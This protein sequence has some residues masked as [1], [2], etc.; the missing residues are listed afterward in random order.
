MAASVPVVS[1]RRTILIWGLRVILALLFFATAFGKLSSQA[2]MV[3]EFETIGMGR[4]FLY[5]TGALELFGALAVL[6][7]RISVYG[8]ALLFCIAIGAFVAQVLILHMD[9]VHTIVIAAV[10]AT[11]VYLQRDKLGRFAR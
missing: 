11:A 6:I 8:A 3:A 4:W 1:R 7:P 10:A 5:L 9:W 2:M